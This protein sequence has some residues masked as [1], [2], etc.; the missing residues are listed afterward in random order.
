MKSLTLTTTLTLLLHPL[1]TTA[2]NLIPA[3]YPSCAQSCPLLQQAAQSCMSN[4]SAAQSC[5][6]QSA[7][8]GQLY[9]PNPVQVCSQCSATDMLSIQNGYKSQCKA[10][11]APAAANVQVQQQPT[12]TTTST[13][14][15]SA[16][17]SPTSQGS[18]S[19]QGSTN[20]QQ[21]PWYALP[22]LSLKPS[23][24]TKHQPTGCPPTGN[25]S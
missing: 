17:A 12:S 11:G 22:I 16:T 5:F 13:S 25:G 21:G 3:S 4:P 15:T 23:L 7:L 2:Q 20:A 8:L 24:F 9:N 10:A 1:L 18:V 14:A 6:C 19:H